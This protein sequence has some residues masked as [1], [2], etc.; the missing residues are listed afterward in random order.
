MEHALALLNGKVS[1]TA[2]GMRRSATR[3]NLSPKFIHFAYGFKAAQIME[4]DFAI[5]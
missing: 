4:R 1:D 3:R 2:A 5:V